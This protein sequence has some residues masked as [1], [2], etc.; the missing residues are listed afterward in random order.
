M[1]IL[2]SAKPGAR[3]RQ[4]Q[5]KH[6]NPLFE[7]FDAVTA[8]SVEAARKADEQAYHDFIASFEKLVEDILALE[9][10]A[11]T[12]DV[13]DLKT[14]LDKAFEDSAVL[15]GDLD[16]IHDAIQRLMAPMMQAIYKNAENDPAALGT[17]EEEDTAR[18]K[19]YALL[20]NP[21]IADLLSD[22]TPIVPDE[23]AATLLSSHV[24][25]LE[26]AMELFSPEQCAVI[27]D[28]ASNLLNR[29]E[30]SGRSTA[31]ALPQF[32]IIENA[33]KGGVSAVQN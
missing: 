14:R 9:P 16:P 13:L 10:Q 21:L 24:A 8:E 28:D 20:E 30:Q 5:R 31:F 25:L 4:Q 23:L 19:H 26:Q 15:P 3:E 12:Q 2:F 11:E 18:A 7:D 17:L 32:K 22:T 29:L 27:L 33:A 6:N 1:S